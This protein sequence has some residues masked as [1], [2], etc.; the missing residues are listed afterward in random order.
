[1]NQIKVL[2][3]A[4]IEKEGKILLVQEGDKDCYGDW[5]L[6]TGHLE[7]NEDI[8]A[9]TLR[10]I[11]EET[12]YEAEIVD[13]VRIYEYEKEGD[14][15]F[16]FTFSARIISGEE[17]PGHDILKIKW[18]SKEEL[19]IMK[20]SEFRNKNLK[21]MLNDYYDGKRYDKEVIMKLIGG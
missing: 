4:I 13:L 9:G 7:P 11:K 17:N 18:F 19:E 1:V 2:V 8:F 15:K 3:A 10:E 14:N 6:P 21:K 5:N 12:G 20:D 16:R